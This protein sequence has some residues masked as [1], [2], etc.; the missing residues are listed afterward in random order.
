MACS[1]GRA[2]P[3]AQTKLRLFSDSAGYCQRPECHH[4][5]FSDESGED[6]HIA[7]MAHIFA[8]TDNGPRANTGLSKT[9]RAAYDNLI[10]LC[11]N[12]HT[13]IDKAPDT[14][15]DDRILEWKQSHKETIKRALGVANLSSRGEIR[16]FIDPLLRENKAIFDNFGPDN[17]YHE[18]PEAEEAAVWKKKMLSKIIPNNQKILLALDTKIEFANEEELATI[19][20]FRQHLD[21]IV[22]RH[23]GNGGIQA[24]RFPAKFNGIFKD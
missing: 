7:E 14:F 15:T 16:R 20:L 18:N 22:E 3:S 19:E 21:S 5:L 9:E 13:E 1:K 24:S 4:P 10:L 2:N 11:P 17:T 8:A 12:C 23:L 6:Y